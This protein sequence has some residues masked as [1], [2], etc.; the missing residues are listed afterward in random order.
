MDTAKRVNQAR[1]IYNALKPNEEEQSPQPNSYQSPY[2]DPYQNPYQ[3]GYSQATY[4][5]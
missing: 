2:Q 1:N 4:G 5:M 3:D